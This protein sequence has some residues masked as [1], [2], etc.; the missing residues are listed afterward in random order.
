MKFLKRQNK[1]LSEYEDQHHTLGYFFVTP[2]QIVE[3]K[4]PN[5]KERPKRR[6]QNAATPRSTLPISNALAD[7]TNI[8]GTI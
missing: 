1:L 2:Y 7:F 8:G 5:D 4:L 6:K 3:L